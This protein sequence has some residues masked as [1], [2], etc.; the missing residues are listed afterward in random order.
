MMYLL[1][2]NHLKKATCKYVCGKQYNHS[3]GS[4]IVWNTVYLHGKIGFHRHRAVKPNQ[5]IPLPQILFSNAVIYVPAH[6]NVLMKY[7]SPKYNL[8]HIWSY[9]DKW[10][11]CEHAAMWNAFLSLLWHFLTYKLYFWLC[12]FTRKKL[13]TPVTMPQCPALVSDWI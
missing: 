13:P 10:A 4:R 5:G 3:P 12:S 9:S 2:V 8:I 6:I 1:N 7:V 11:M